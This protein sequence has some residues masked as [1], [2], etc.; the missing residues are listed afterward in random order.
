M[1]LYIQA[2]RNVF[3]AIICLLTITGVGYTQTNFA[4]LYGSTGM[5]YGKANAVDRDGNY[6]NGCLFQNSI[7]FNPAGSTILTAPGATTHIALTKYNRNGELLWAKAFGGVTTSEAPHGIEC[8][9]AG[10]IY[11]TGY[12]GSTFQT[13]PQPADFNPDGGGTIFSQGNEDCFLA[14]YD[15]DGNYVWAFGLGNTGQN[16]QERAWDIAVDASGNSYVGGGFRGTVNFNPLG[17]A[18]NVSLPDTLAGLFIAKYNKSGLLQWV[19]PINAQCNNV[20]TEAYVALDLDNQGNLCAGGNFRGSG[21]NINPLGTTTLLTSSGLTDFFIAK[22]NSETGVLLWVNKTGGTSADVISPGALRCDKTGKIWFTGRLSG[23][24]TVDFDPGQGVANVSN[25]SLF[26]AC[27]G[28]GGEFVMAKGMNS[29]AG[30]GGHRITFDSGNNIYLAGWMNGT[31]DFGNGITRSAFSSTADVLLAKF[32]QAGECQWA[33]NF[34]GNG[35]SENNI[36]AGLL[37]D[38]EDNL[39]ITGQ[40]YGTG[41][42]TDPGSGTLLMSSA[43]QNDCF[44]IKYKSDGSLWQNTPSGLEN[45]GSGIPEFR[46]T[47]NYPNP[48]NPNTTIFFSLEE[49]GTASVELYDVT[50]KMISLITVGY[51]SAGQNRVEFVA[52]DLTSG[53]YYY[54]IITKTGSFTGKMVLMR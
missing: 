1:K 38:D 3:A 23:T 41:A 4:L 30:D 15:K 8:D 21:V 22:Y 10:N 7:N 5:E 34:G 13:G 12:F 32:T 26:L 2:I 16:T 48:F 6:I 25:S 11:V 54:R 29:G 36:C 17:N 45:E 35:S 9:S 18:V 43:G 47:G 44:V 31:A 19:M 28:A 20:F 51:F 14:K 49:P 40:L 53:V 24:G 27:Y 39:Y 50:G 37:A 42:D 33:F 46:I 52:D